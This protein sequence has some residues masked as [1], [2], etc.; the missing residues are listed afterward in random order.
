MTL[1]SVY[2]GSS[3][4]LQ[5]KALKYCRKSFCSEWS[6]VQGLSNRTYF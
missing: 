2:L 5:Q 6:Q 4:N 3:I 1:S